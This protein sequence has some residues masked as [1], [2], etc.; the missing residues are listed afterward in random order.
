M[1][2]SPG[3]A[4]KD[5]NSV[6]QSEVV[7]ES[8]ITPPTTPL[9]ASSP[10]AAS[11]SVVASVESPEKMARA[12]SGASPKKDIARAHLEEETKKLDIRFRDFF[13]LELHWKMTTTYPKADFCQKI[14]DLSVPRLSKSAAE[15]LEL[16]KKNFF[17][18]CINVYY[19]GI[20]RD[21]RNAE[22]FLPHI[23][24]T[25]IYEGYTGQPIRCATGHYIKAVGFYNAISS[26]RD[27]L[28]SFITEH[29]VQLSDE[30][31]NILDEMYSYM[32]THQHVLVDSFAYLKM[33]PDWYQRVRNEM[34]NKA[35]VTPQTKREQRDVRA[36]HGQ[37]PQKTPVKFSDVDE[38]ECQ[39]LRTYRESLSPI[40]GI[41][42]SVAAAP[43][44][45]SVLMA[46]TSIFRE[47]DFDD[48][49]K[50]QPKV[51]L[52]PRSL[53][54]DETP[55]SHDDYSS[56]EEGG[57]NRGLLAPPSLRSQLPLQRKLFD[58]DEDVDGADIMR[59]LSLPKA[60]PK[61]VGF[62]HQ[63]LLF[64]RQEQPI[65]V[66]GSNLLASSDDFSSEDDQT[67]T[68]APVM[69]EFTLKHK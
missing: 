50:S 15:K 59:T 21:A 53:F 64:S 33:R 37:T 4:G 44:L 35:N 18:N 12:L 2:R 42:A 29:E 7:E 45:E 55:L 43:S 48:M 8:L 26:F 41:K 34:T 38:K 66:L 40:K 58:S 31:L 46:E 19:L 17:Q 60:R 9:R 6:S 57:V 63:T 32:S 22:I 54:Q 24:L 69:S 25:L 5:E 62:S 56:D 30:Q 3:A 52:S 20:D 11:S 36:T 49:F 39:Q 28:N 65:G 51:D 14:L 10:V 1:L 23:A 47:L 61:N 67:E 68:L 13:S 16:L 27:K